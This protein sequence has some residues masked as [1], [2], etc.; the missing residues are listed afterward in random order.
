M[1]DLDRRAAVITGH[2]TGIGLGLTVAYTG[3]GVSR[4]WASGP[5]SEPVSLERSAAVALRRPVA[6]FSDASAHNRA[7]PLARRTVPTSGDAGCAERRQPRRPISLSP[8]QRA[9]EASYPKAAA[10]LPHGLMTRATGD[11][12]PI[13]GKS[14]TPRSTIAFARWQADTIGREGAM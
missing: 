5:E 6:H 2:A 7:F 11:R 1:R 13:D 9:D 14:V 4:C 3:I 10:A 12:I 8:P